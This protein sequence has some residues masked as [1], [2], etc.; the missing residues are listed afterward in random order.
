MPSRNLL[1]THYVKT[2]PQST[3]NVEPVNP[4]ISHKQKS[5]PQVVTYDDINKAIQSYPTT[6]PTYDYA[7][8]SPLKE[9]FPSKVSNDNGIGFLVFG[10]LVMAFV[11]AFL[12][13]DK[14]SGK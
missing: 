9:S 10:G 4:P 13:S 1:N 11:A 6:R 5:S 8:E 14:A 12:Y 2:T 7:K 3:V